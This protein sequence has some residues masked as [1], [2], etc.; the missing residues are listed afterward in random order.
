MK[1]VL[2]IAV[3]WGSAFL[4]MI[5]FA[6][7]FDRIL[8]N[9]K[10]AVD[11]LI[12]IL[13]AIAVIVFAWGIVQFIMAAGDEEKRANGRQLMI[14]GVVGIA[15]IVGIWGLVGVVLNFF[16]TSAGTSITLP[17]VN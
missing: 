13:V 5:V 8:T 15:V 10:T 14:W 4:P 7:D 1:K 17:R 3:G 9:T 6:Q 12:P 2:K 11:K 16:G